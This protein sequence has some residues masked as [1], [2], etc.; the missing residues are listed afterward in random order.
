MAKR[1]DFKSIE[2]KWQRI[3]EERDA[4]RVTEDPGQPKYYCLEMYPY[5]SGKIHM[6]HLRNY[7]IGDVVARYF[8]MRGYNVLH[9]MGW[10]SFGLP[11]ENAAIEHGLHP[12]TWTSDNIAYMREQLKRMGFSYD[13]GREITCSEPDYY[14]WNQWLFLKMY[15]K[16]L[17]YKKP[18]FLNWCEECQTVLANEQVE[19][20]RCWRDE[21]EVIQ[22]EL[23]QWFFKITAYTEELLEGVDQLPGWPD[24]VKTMQRNWIGKSVGAE[25]N[26]PLLNGESPITIFTTRQDT[27]FGA[28]FMVLAP[29]HPLALQLGEG[30]AGVQ[31]FIKRMRAEDRVVRTAADTE[32]EGVFTG[33]YAINPLTEEKI[34]IWV[35]NFVLL[36]YGTGAIMAVPAHDQRDFEFAKKYHLPIRVV[37]QPEE[38]GLAAEALA[39]A[40]QDE[41][42]MVNSGPFNSLPS[43]EGREAVVRFLEE[44]GIGK[45]AVN[46]RLRDWG[47]SR[48]RY[49]GTPIPII[50]CD[51][52]G[53][54]PV[55]YDDL[56]VLL[57]KDVEISMKGGSP[58]AKVESFVNVR[59]PTCR[60]PARR[61]TDTM[62]TF[63]DSSWYFLRF[64]NPHARDRAVDELKV[65]YWMPVDQ[66]IGGIEHAVLHLLYARF[67]TKVVRD[68]GLIPHSEPFVNLLTQGMVCK[69]TYRCPTHGFRFPQEIDP[70][71]RCTECAHP[72]EIGRTEKMSKSRKN[73]VD[74]DDLLKRYGA[75]TARLFSLFA[76]PPEKDLEWSD[77][78]VE[79]AF[80]FLNRVY[81]LVDG[82]ADELSRPAAPI[83]FNDLTVGRAVHQKAHLTIKKVTE[84][85]DRDFHFNTAIAALM[86]L[87][88]VLGQF[89]LRGDPAEEAERRYVARFAVETLLVL[90][91]PFAPHLAE[92]LWEHLGHGSSIFAE[93]WPAYDA[94]VIE[95]EEI[96]VVVQVDGKLRSRIF[97]P[98]R[99]EE[100][101]LRTAALQDS[102]VQT[103]LQ[104]R[105]VKRVVVVPKKLVNIVTARS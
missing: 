67:F 79:G 98:A 29:E 19:G 80:R 22:K 62:D 93:S 9:P 32:K 60:G 103:W 104:G 20:G 83:S 23:E 74:P 58:L 18:A 102:R 28:T 96:L 72:V 86:E 14:R 36:E 35:A 27:L 65:A 84:D 71:G 56:P 82:W 70:Q 17:A 57:P 94:A 11:A 43:P 8:R 85:L 101:E 76:A 3:W 95:R 48:Q 42:V 37:I 78:G 68:L 51:Q 45:G 100:E 88:N 44:R 92:E 52:C 75:D 59:C 81:R 6:G 12:A 15:A 90:L 61:E 16:G 89:E 25:V 33:A 105:Q 24:R 1:Y 47:I 64:C 40:Y 77:K 4:F 26:F 31:A 5:P 91:A 99:A 13:W 66:Y 53:T 41:G 55:P 46:Y 38:E 97:L 21:S 30:K 10:D 63:V 87:V 39:K 73:V 34:P 49:W 2:A 7:S 69:E 50:Y 54:V